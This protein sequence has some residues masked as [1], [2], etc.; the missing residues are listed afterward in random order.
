M[1]A[2]KFRFEADFHEPVPFLV[3]YSRLMKALK[4]FRLETGDRIIELDYVADYP[5][6]PG[7]LG[8]HL[9]FSGI[10]S[11]ALDSEALSLPDL[12][13]QGY[14]EADIPGRIRLAW[15]R[16]PVIE[17]LENFQAAQPT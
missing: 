16:D 8:Y 17:V 9:T 11:P 1:Q 14:Y 6:T 7:L 4:D 15:N 12:V 3:K 2:D 5:E 13:Y 10:W